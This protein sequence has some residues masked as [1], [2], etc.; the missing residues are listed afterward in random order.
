MTTAAQLPAGSGDLPPTDD[1]PPIAT[2]EP[3]PPPDAAGP[4]PYEPIRPTV[5]PRPTVAPQVWDDAHAALGYPLDHPYVRRYWVPVIG[6]GAVADLLRLAVAADRGRSLPRP[7]HLPPLVRDELAMIDTD[8]VYVRCRIPP[9][10]IA[11]G[12]RLP[13][14]LRRDHAQER[15]ASPD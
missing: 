10:S 14:R 1:R 6:P 13:T 3:A 4:L 2:R 11:Q 15:L 12:K 8:E 9:L 5:W 7:V